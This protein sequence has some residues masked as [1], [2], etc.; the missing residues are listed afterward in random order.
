MGQTDL[1]VVSFG[2]NRELLLLRDAV[3]RSSGFDVFTTEN[4]S[5][6]LARISRGDC[7]VLLVCYSAPLPLKRQLAVAYKNRCPDGRIIAVANEHV[8]TL[9]VGDSFVYGME[10]PE[11]LIEAI[12]GNP[13]Q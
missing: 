9:D 4:E 5:E 7:G 1:N 12:R 10:G 2:K 6:A 3:L 13:R 8:E 11:V